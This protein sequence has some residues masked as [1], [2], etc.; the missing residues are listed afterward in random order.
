[1]L[2]NIEGV[3]GKTKPNTVS[4]V[5]I[6]PILTKLAIMAMLGFV[7]SLHDYKNMGLVID[8]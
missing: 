2:V 5:H 4:F 3:R 6:D 7:F 1:M 8:H